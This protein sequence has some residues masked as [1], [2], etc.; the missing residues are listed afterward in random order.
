M[1]DA[2]MHR[3]PDAGSVRI[4]PHA[5]LGH[6]RLAIIDIATGAQP[7]CNEDGS[8]WLVFNGEI[9]NYHPCAP[10]SRRRATGSARRR[11]P[12]PSSM[13]SRNGGRPVSTAS[14]ACSPSWSTTREPRVTFAARDRL[15]KKPLFH[16]VLGGQLHLASE[17]K[18]IKKSPLWT[19]DLDEDVL[20]AYLALGYIPAPRTA[21]RGVSKLLPGHWLRHDRNGLQIQR[22]WDVPSFDED[23]RD[24]ATVLESLDALFAETVRDRLESEVP[25]GAFLSGGIDSGLV[26]SYMA[27]DAPKPP[28]TLTVGFSEDPANELAAARATATALGTDHHDD[29]VKVDL[30]PMLGM[31]AAPSTNRL[32]IRQRSRR[33]PCAG[34]RDGT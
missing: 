32:P 27:E 34:P 5:V 16:A 9:Y 26:V 29:L 3:G 20:D 22:Y 4:S 8:V 18:S 2:L 7:M 33:L 17:L 6:R 19:G 11:T 25:L 15:G 21:Y 23:Q 31:I 24:E 12:R 10:N 13:P 14:T 28:V 1:T 30:E